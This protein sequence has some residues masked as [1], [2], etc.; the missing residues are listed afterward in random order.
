MQFDLLLFVLV[1]QQKQLRDWEHYEREK[2]TLLAHM[3]KVKNEL[4][5]PIETLSQE[6]AQKDLQSKKVFVLQGHSDEKKTTKKKKKIIPDFFFRIH[7]SGEHF[8][9]YMSTGVL[10]PNIIYQ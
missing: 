8:H 4:E 9:Y 7:S 5:K 10:C 2:T 3:K 1:F 6:S